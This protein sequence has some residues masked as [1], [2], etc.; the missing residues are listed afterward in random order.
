MERIGAPFVNDPPP[1]S[2]SDPHQPRPPSDNPSARNMTAET[3]PTAGSGGSGSTAG[4]ART[5]TEYNAHMKGTAAP[6]SQSELFG[7]TPRDKNVHP[8]PDSGPSTGVIGTSGHKGTHD[9][10]TGTRDP[11][12]TAGD[13]RGRDEGGQ[14]GEGGEKP[15]LLDRLNPMKDSDQDGKKGIED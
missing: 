6:G 3:I 11:P 9:M 12:N 10:N 8:P 4:S 7:L 5:G 15:S 1:T 13:M 2:S 14:A